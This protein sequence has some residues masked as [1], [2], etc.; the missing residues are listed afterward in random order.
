MSPSITSYTSLSSSLLPLSLSLPLSPSDW[1]RIV[2]LIVRPNSLMGEVCQINWTFRY[3]SIPWWDLIQTVLNPAKRSFFAPLLKIV[4][5][6][7]NHKIYFY[8]SSTIYSRG[9]QAFFIDALP[10]LVFSK[11]PLRKFTKIE[12]RTQ[13][14][15]LMLSKQWSA[16]LLSSI[17]EQGFF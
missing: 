9:G 7:K 12:G 8:R 13:N 2:R 17:K 10:L 4:N 16:F 11:D 14:L 15:I 5:D 6:N 3:V 1:Q